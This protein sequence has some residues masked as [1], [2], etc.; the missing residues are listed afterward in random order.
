MKRSFRAAAVF[1]G[2]AVAGA[3]T[4]AT[5]LVPA[6]QAAQDNG[7]LRVFDCKGNVS[8]PYL[9]LYWLPSKHHP[10]PTCYSG[11]VNSYASPQTRFRSYCAGIYSGY[12]SIEGQGPKNFTEGTHNL[13]GAYISQILI[14]YSKNKGNYCPNASHGH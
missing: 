2:T 4:G 3:M 13:Y 9:H 12:F 6:A 10:S 7:P 14:T 1:T 5:G 11:K 8:T